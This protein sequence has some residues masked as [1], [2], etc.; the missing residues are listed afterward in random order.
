MYDIDSTFSGLAILFVFVLVAGVL[1][2]GILYLVAMQKALDAVSEENRKIPSG[3][4]WLMLIPLFNIV[5][6]FILVARIAD[7]FRD[8][9]SKLNI[10]YNEPRPTYNIG[11]TK[12][13]L[14]VCGIVPLLGYLASFASLIC[15]IIYWVKVNECRRLVEANRS[16]VLLDAEMGVFHSN[17]QQDQ[18]KGW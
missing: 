12:C 16:N 10:D 2:L 8:E 15:W 14:S 13:I 6:A 11:L 9:F 1:V 17:N 5:W 4:V 18:L 7:S 3:Q